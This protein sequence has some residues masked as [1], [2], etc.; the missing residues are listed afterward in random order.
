[1]TSRIELLTKE[2]AAYRIIPAVTRLFPLCS[3]LIYPDLNFSCYTS[4]KM[5]HKLT[6]GGFNY[7]K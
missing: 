1:M 6:N 7:G 5:Q 3:Y 4:T 2:A